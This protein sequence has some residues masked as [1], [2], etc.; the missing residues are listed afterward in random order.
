MQGLCSLRGIFV[1]VRGQTGREGF[2]VPAGLVW[3][4]FE[5]VEIQGCWL[6]PLTLW[7]KGKLSHAGD[8]LKNDLDHVWIKPL[9]ANWLIHSGF[10]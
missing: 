3:V 2:W 9:D 4:R 1:R 8:A 10:G 5:R 6:C 7:D